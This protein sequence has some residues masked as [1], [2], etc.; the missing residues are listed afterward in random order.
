LPARQDKVSVSF[1]RTPSE[2]GPTRIQLCGRLKADVDGRH[3]T[4][5]LRGRQG[6]VLLAYLVLNRG[7]A[8]GRDELIAAIWP[9]TPPADPPAALRTQLSRL[10]SALG[11]EALAGRDAVELRLPPSTWIDV[12]A[13]EHAI[14][15]AESALRS[16]DWKDAWAH[17]HIALNISGRPFLA[18][19][20]A[21]WVEDVR[22]D[23]EEL[24]LRSREVIARAGIGLGGS[25]LAGAERSAR[26]LIRSAP[27]RESGHLY[28]MEALAASGNTAEALRTYEELRRLLA[29]ELGAA[30]GAEAQALHRR[31]LTGSV[32]NGGSPASGTAIADSANGVPALIE[33]AVASRL[34]KLGDGARR[35]LEAAAVV[36]GE[37]QS[38]LLAEVSGLAEKEVGSCLE[39]AVGAGILSESTAAGYAFQHPFFRQVVYEGAS[40]SARA[41]LHRRLAEALEA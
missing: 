6:R 39:A 31:L 24:S 41:A 38:P 29:E 36:G 17:G 35:V 22:R 25:E 30:P 40:R 16:G 11:T 20:D 10:R 28:L 3:V 27:F 26:A 5:L 14:A 21:A 2:A 4:P 32:G 9:D 33:E 13:A 7:R 18:G 23:L 8:V 37:F 12:E 34:D 1:P 15:A 19:F